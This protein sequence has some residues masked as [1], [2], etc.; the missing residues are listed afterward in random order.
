MVGFVAGA[1]VV[2]PCVEEPVEVV[3]WPIATVPNSSTAAGS[4]IHFENWKLMVFYSP[5]F[6]LD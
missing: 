1:V 6:L 5:Y 4:T 3:S 2:V